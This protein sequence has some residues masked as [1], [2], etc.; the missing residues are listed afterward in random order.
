M[1]DGCNEG[2]KGQMGFINTFNKVK[3]WLLEGEK[4]LYLIKNDGFNTTKA[5]YLCLI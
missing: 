3:R 1:G 5:F 4:G 2:Y